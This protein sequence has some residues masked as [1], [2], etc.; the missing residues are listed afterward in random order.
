MG[1]SANC[2]VASNPPNESVN[3]LKKAASVWRYGASLQSLQVGAAGLT[4][5]EAG[6]VKWADELCAKMKEEKVLAGDNMYR[7]Y[8]NDAET[9]L[10]QLE[11]KGLGQKAQQVRTRKD[12]CALFHSFSNGMVQNLGRDCFLAT[13]EEIA[14]AFRV[15]DKVAQES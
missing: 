1:P 15:F 10:I 12:A 8:N 5:D 9:L 13:G 14:E 11:A 4:N 6:L 2:F 7:K 3:S